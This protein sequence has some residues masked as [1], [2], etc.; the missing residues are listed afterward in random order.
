MYL[1]YTQWASSSPPLRE[2]LGQVGARSLRTL[3]KQTRVAILLLF[4]RARF[5][6][7]SVMTTGRARLLDQC[8]RAS[9]RNVKKD[10]PRH[11]RRDDVPDAVAEEA[12][13]RE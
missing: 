1:R 8:A 2:K 13:G 12:E 9:P 4:I 6:L 3:H 10:H 5:P 11:P 7:S